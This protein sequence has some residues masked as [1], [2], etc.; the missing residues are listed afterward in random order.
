M[1]STPGR[2]S[3]LKLRSRRI[4]IEFTNYR[5]IGKSGTEKYSIEH[6]LSEKTDEAENLSETLKEYQVHS[7]KQNDL[8][9]NI[10]EVAEK[11]IIELK[12]TL[13]KKVLESQEY[14][15]HLQTTLNQLNVLKQENAALKEYIA[16]IASLHQSSIT[17][18]R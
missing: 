12:M 13:D 9:R 10:S 3:L 17:A 15:G 2:K 4:K 18:A 14:Y 6:R 11:K 7:E 5:S 16:K 8:I 1:R